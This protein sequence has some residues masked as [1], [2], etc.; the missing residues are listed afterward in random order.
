MVFIQIVEK[1]NRKS[2]CKLNPRCICYVTIYVAFVLSSSD[3]FA[4]FSY[5]YFFSQA[6]KNNSRFSFPLFSEIKGIKF[7]FVQSVECWSIF[8]ICC[9][10]HF[11]VHSSGADGL[12]RYF[13]NE[14]LFC[15]PI[16]SF[17]FHRINFLPLICSSEPIKSCFL[18]V[19]NAN[20][21]LVLWIIDCKIKQSLSY[22]YN[23][24]LQMFRLS[25]SREF[26][27]KTECK[28]ILTIS[29]ISNTEKCWSSINHHC[30]KSDNKMTSFQLV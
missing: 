4:A 21:I 20:V 23:S 22:F 13:G 29:T 18:F 6:S 2:C 10:N 7:I 11:T 15:Q 28:E 16:F 14:R 3:W 17:Y 8:Y 30:Y 12:K 25:C 26:N 1:V 27:W 5:L 9:K 19:L 24:L